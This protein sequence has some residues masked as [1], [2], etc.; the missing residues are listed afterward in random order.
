MQ[1]DYCTNEAE[2]FSI[3]DTGPERITRNLCFECKYAEGPEDWG[4]EVE[5]SAICPFCRN[6]DLGFACVC[7]AETD[8]SPSHVHFLNW[9]IDIVSVCETDDFRSIEDYQ[10][11]IRVLLAKVRFGHVFDAVVQVRKHNSVF[12][13]AVI[14]GFV[15]TL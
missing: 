2:S 1:C 6:E 8:C 3:D 11:W 4:S 13:K 7:Q 15:E 5:D 12:D 10:K 14:C 9:A